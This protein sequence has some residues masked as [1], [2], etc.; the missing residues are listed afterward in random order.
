ML[1]LTG[2]DQSAENPYDPNGDVDLDGILNK[3]DTDIDGDGLSNEI[4]TDTH[5]TSPYIADTDGDGWRDDE[6]INNYV[7]TYPPKFSP[8]IADLPALKLRLRSDPEVEMEYFTTTGTEAS[9][10]TSEGSSSTS[11][12]TNTNSLTQTTANEYGWSVETGIEFGRT[13]GHMHV[14]GHVNVGAHG[15]YTQEESTSWTNSRTV[16]NTRQ[17]ERA[18][19]RATS[20]SLQNRG[21]RISVSV[22]FSNLSNIAYTV[23]DVMLSAYKLDPH[24]DDFVIPIATLECGSGLNVSLRPQ[25]QDDSRFIFENDSLTVEKVL[26]L[27]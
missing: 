15:T 2:E 24:E 26:Q 1:G 14:V 8:L 23:S 7:D 22:S 5:H 6:E 17:V 20:E 3:D 9:Y 11:S 18:R 10:S 12:F 16:E 27:L 21:G 13:S 4:E 25:R 19:S